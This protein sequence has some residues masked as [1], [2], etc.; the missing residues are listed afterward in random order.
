MNWKNGFEVRFPKPASNT[1]GESSGNSSASKNTRL[2]LRPIILPTDSRALPGEP[3]IIKIPAES[4]DRRSA[5]TGT[6]YALVSTRFPGN[7]CTA[8]KSFLTDF[9]TRCLE[10]EMEVEVINTNVSS[11]SHSQ[12]TSPYAPAQWD[13]ALLAHP[14]IAQ[15]GLFAPVI[16]CSWN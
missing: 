9:Q 14:E 3:A 4:S 2:F 6:I 10:S 7:P 8:S 5:R 16:G 1:A 12:L 11:G 15:C 13:F